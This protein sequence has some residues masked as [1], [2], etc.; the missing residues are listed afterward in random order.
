MPATNPCQVKGAGTEKSPERP[1][2]SITQVYALA[3]ATG[4]RYRA[5][6]LLACFCGLRWGELAALR[7]CDLDIATGTV[8]VA[9]QLNE[10]S[11][12]LTWRFD[13]RAWQDSN[14]RPAA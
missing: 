6:V 2:L 13:L 11:G 12:Q 7:R 10:V 14:L 8:R 1:V 4:A 9:R 5:L 3:D